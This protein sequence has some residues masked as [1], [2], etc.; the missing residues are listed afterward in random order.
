ML[1]WFDTDATR[2]AAANLRR[3]TAE[4]VRSGVTGTEAIG[5]A[6]IAAL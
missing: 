4:A 6:I 2:A 3:A 5:S 1:E